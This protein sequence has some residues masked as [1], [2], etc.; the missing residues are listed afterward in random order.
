MVEGGKSFWAD[1]FFGCEGKWVPA[2][3]CDSRKSLEGLK[4]PKGRK[5]PIKVYFA[6]L[7]RWHIIAKSTVPSGLSKIGQKRQTSQ[8]E[9]RGWESS[10]SQFLRAN[11]GNKFSIFHPPAHT[12]PTKNDTQLHWMPLSTRHCSLPK[13][14]HG[15]SEVVAGTWADEMGFR[16]GH[17]VT[18]PFVWSRGEALFRHWHVVQGDVDL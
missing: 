2:I 9:I 11:I 4:T 17:W 12:N 1:F 7:K 14:S 3:L 5:M 6:R 16:G 10:N 13:T 18:L 15:P 8:T